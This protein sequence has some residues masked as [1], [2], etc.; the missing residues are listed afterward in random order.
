MLAAAGLAALSTAFAASGGRAAEKPG[1]ADA[2]TRTSQLASLHYAVNIGIREKGTPLSLHIRGQSDAHTLSVHFASQ[3]TSGGELVYGP[4][5][6]EL[7]P[8]GVAILGKMRWLRT[9]LARLSPNSREL[10][11]LRALKIG[12][13]LQLA[14][15]GR[16][17]ANAN[18]SVFN[19][20]VAYDDPVVRDSLSHLTDGLEF[21]GLRLTVHIRRGLID[22]LKLTGKT[23]D[24]SSKLSLSAHLFAFNRPLHLV[25]PKPG[26]FM[27]L[28][29]DQLSE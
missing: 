11:T 9:I 18:G 5:L 28:E 29:L 23:A 14:G 22:R 2:L 3:G 27:D 4:F 7:A 6:Y 25:P 15:R 17:T 24:G 1:V 8:N 21:R 10:V 20:P 16:L 26:T 13:L 12:P 19:G